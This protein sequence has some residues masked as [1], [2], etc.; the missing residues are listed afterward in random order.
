VRAN[1]ARPSSA[2]CA[3]WHA[4]RALLLET[5]GVSTFEIWLSR[6]ELIAID[7]G[8]VMVVT[9]PSETL[10]WMRGRFGGP[11]ARCAQRVGRGLRIADERERAAMATATGPVAVCDVYLQST[12]RRVS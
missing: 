8:R 12:Q 6:L 4:I 5:A 9:G 1:L 11:I 2:D 3:D 7:S 10:S